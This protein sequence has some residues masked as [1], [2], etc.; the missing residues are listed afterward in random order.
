MGRGMVAGD[1][2]VHTPNFCFASIML[3]NENY[4]IHFWACIPSNGM[5]YSHLDESKFFFLCACAILLIYSS[6]IQTQKYR[7]FALN[8]Y[9]SAR[10]P[11]NRTNDVK[12]IPA[13]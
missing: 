2:T 6:L 1:R 9:G 13:N 8:N 11:L 3:S 4:K 7:R 12:K 5:R 10:Q